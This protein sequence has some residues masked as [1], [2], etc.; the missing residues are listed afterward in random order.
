MKV[1]LSDPWSQIVHFIDTAEKEGRADLANFIT[2]GCEVATF[3]GA[4]GGARGAHQ[5][6]FST[7]CQNP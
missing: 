6:D 4:R 3:T 1:N 2:A 5:T 7:A